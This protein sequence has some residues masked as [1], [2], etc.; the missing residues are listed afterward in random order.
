[1]SKDRVRLSRRWRKSN[2]LAAVI[3]EKVTKVRE[4][5]G[6]T[7]EQ[8]ADQL[9]L[10]I[11]IVAAVEEGS[12]LPTQEVAQRF[13]WW[14]IDGYRMEGAHYP[15][16]WQYNAKIDL[17]KIAR[18]TV[19]MDLILLKKLDRVA[20]NLNVPVPILVNLALRSFLDKHSLM[21]SL[22][23]A[24]RQLDEERIRMAIGEAP[25]LVDL[26]N[27]DLEHAKRLGLRVHIRD[28]EHGGPGNEVGTRYLLTNA[29]DLP[30]E[31]GLNSFAATNK[32]DE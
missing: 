16:D 19:A 9:G 14:M 10:P 27:A 7:Q 30:V 17:K 6:Y 20:E 21:N 4:S 15:S 24:K 2:A 22:L 23:E 1:M 5:L 12:H 32:G 13:K 31:L 28:T 11:A 26:A 25:A 18:V 29:L 8:L 3:G